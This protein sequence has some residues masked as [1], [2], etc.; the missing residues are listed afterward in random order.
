M[1]EILVEKMVFRVEFG[2]VVILIEIDEA[3][4][5]TRTVIQ[6]QELKGLNLQEGV[7]ACTQLLYLPGALEQEIWRVH[8]AGRGPDLFLNFS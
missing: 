4:T 8:S 7:H 5:Q 3:M 6:R 1:A 2:S